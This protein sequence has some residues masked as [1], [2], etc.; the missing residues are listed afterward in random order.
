MKQQKATWYLTDF[1]KILLIIALTC[2]V[3][4]GEL[5]TEASDPEFHAYSIRDAESN[6][7]GPVGK[8]RFPGLEWDFNTFHCIYFMTKD[9]LILNKSECQHPWK[10]KEFSVWPAISFQ[11]E[12]FD[13]KSQKKILHHGM[14]LQTIWNSD[15]DIYSNTLKPGKAAQISLTTP[16]HLC[17]STVAV[18]TSRRCG[19]CSSLRQPPLRHIAQNAFPHGAQVDQ[20]SICNKSFAADFCKSEDFEVKWFF[21]LSQRWRFWGHNHDSHHCNEYQYRR[22]LGRQGGFCSHSKQK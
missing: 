19:R 5:N 9:L 21:E 2:E 17:A 14:Q 22:L 15:L 3:S 8:P 16:H 4:A 7:S 1:C 20:S 6:S 11:W 10:L 18:Q 13:V 12:D